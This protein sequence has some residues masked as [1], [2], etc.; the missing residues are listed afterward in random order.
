MSC[1]WII[2]LA[3]AAVAAGATTT[4]V[5]TDIVGASATAAA[6][7]VRRRPADRAV[8][9]ADP[10]ASASPSRSSSGARFA[11]SIEAVATGLLAGAAAE[12][13]NIVLL[14][15]AAARLYYAIIMSHPGV[16]PTSTPSTPT[17]PAW[18]PTPP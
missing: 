5:E 7:P 8:R 18:S 9:A 11:V 16:Q 14:R 10:A 15:P 4:G 17:W 6:R 1:M 3:V 2:V 13:A 12:V